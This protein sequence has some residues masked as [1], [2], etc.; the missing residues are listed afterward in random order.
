MLGQ[1]QMNGNIGL[2]ATFGACLASGL[3]A[4]SFERVL[5]DSA[6]ATSIW[7][8]NVQLAVYS[9]V[10]SL[11]FGV[12]F[13]DG[14][15]VAKAGFFEGYNSVVWM[16]IIAQTLG[17]IGTSLCFAGSATNLKLAAGGMSM[18]LSI[19]A[20][21]WLFDFNATFTVS[22]L[23]FLRYTWRY[24]TNI[25][26]SSYWAPDWFS[27]P[28]IFWSMERRSSS[29]AAIYERR[30]FVYR[31]SKNPPAHPEQ[32]GLILP[33]LLQ[34]TSLSN[35]RLR[36]LCHSQLHSALRDLVHLCATTLV[37]THLVVRTSQ[38]KS[39][40]RKYT[41]VARHLSDYIVP[42]YCLL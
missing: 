36:R 25:Y 29:L 38:S 39:T 9:I 7:V 27:G 30:Q 3:A 17:G 13:L 37:F 19:F 18:V 11:F 21:V 23:L 32:V 35:Y 31:I 8:R 14:E 26:S 15:K 33:Y 4:V 28:Y 40:T 5:K 10:P 12:V 2:L 1:L 20:S 34:M 22:W 24:L 6:S 42:L 16:A 41:W